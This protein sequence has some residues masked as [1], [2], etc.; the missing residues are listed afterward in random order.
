MNARTSKAQGTGGFTLLEIMIVIMVISILIA[1]AVPNFINAR[2]SGRL[3]ACISNLK[4]IES[5]KEQYALENSINNG[6]PVDWSNL[7]PTYVREQPVCPAGG[8]YDLKVIGITATCSF[9]GHTF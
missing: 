7:I 2:S 5:A 3:K 9:E 8:D 1:V 4:Q 6:E